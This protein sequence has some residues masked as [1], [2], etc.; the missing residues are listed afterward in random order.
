M[1]MSRHGRKWLRGMWKATGTIASEFE[2]LSPVTTLLGARLV[3]SFAAREHA[4]GKD[5]EEPLRV[6]I[7]YGYAARMV[8]VEPTDQPSL[9]P[10]AFR[11]N[12]QSDVERLANDAA[13]PKRLLDPVRTIASDKF[14]SVMTLPPEVW[15]GL[16]AL[17]TQ[18][19]QRRF[20]S[21]NDKKLTWRD[22]SQD[23][24]EK[25]LRYGYVLRCLDEALDAEPELR[26][27]APDAEAE[28]AA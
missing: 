19:L 2:A 22:L 14:D 25:M 17:A 7:V 12:P 3:E 23:R 16:V 15:S 26:Q 24:V 9:R 11:L 28:A 18:T 1:S 5:L 27:P 21:S 20:T 8:L 4:E 13:T 10:S 6:A